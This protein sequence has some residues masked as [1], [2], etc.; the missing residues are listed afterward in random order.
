MLYPWVYFA[1]LPLF[2]LTNADVSFGGLDVETMLNS[3][4]VLGVF[5]GLVLGKPIGIM[6]LSFITVK[7]RIASLPENV[8]WMHMLGAAILGGV[9]FTMAIFVANLAYADE[10]LITEAKLSILIASLV[11]GII[12]FT[13]L[14]VQASI[15]QKR[16]VNYVTTKKDAEHLSHADREAARAADKLV[17]ELADEELA[18]RLAQEREDALGTRELVV[19]RRKRGEEQR[20]E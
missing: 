9:G 8:N 1:I 5:C 7:T 13:L 11:A 18:E 14:F 17:K 20:R 19:E 12:G 2:A 16:G 15:A 3:T 6:L 4:V 10:I